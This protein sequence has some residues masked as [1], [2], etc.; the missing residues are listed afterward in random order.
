MDAGVPRGGDDGFVRH[1]R[2]PQGDVVAQGRGKKHHVLIHHG[3]GSPQYFFGYLMPRMAIEQDFAGPGLIDTRN[4]ARQRGFAGTAGAD[5]GNPAPRPDHQVEVLDQRRPGLVVAEGDLPQFDA[6]GKLQ[7][8]V[9]RGDRLGLGTSAGENGVFLRLGDVF[10][11]LHVRIERL[12]LVREF[13]KAPDR[14][15]KHLRQNVEPHERTQRDVPGHHP[16]GSDAQ[17]RR[18]TQC[19]DETGKRGVEIAQF[20]IAPARIQFAR[21]LAAPA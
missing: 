3:N 19:G 6:A 16:G 11:P 13:Q 7:P 12:A 9:E 4:Q 1:G 5:H 8:A 21:L 15:Q 2:V 18:G 20:G 10:Q 17:D 14:R